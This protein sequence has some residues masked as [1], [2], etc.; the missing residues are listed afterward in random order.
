MVAL[1]WNLTLALVLARH[2]YC[3]DNIK[4][5]LFSKHLLQRKRQYGSEKSHGNDK[6]LEKNNVFSY[7]MDQK[8]FIDASCIYNIHTE[9]KKFLQLLLLKVCESFRFGHI[10]KH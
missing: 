10:K 9:E 7:H 5:E 6:L 8:T 1:F 4:Y 3:G 2:C